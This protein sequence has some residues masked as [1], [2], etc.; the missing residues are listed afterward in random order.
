M[1][2]VKTKSFKDSLVGME[3]PCTI[4]EINT[5]K[6]GRSIEDIIENFGIKVNRNEGVDLI[7]YGVEVKSR[8]SYAGTNITIATMQRDYVINTPYKQSIA[9]KKLQQLRIVDYDYDAKKGVAVIVAD[10]VYDWSDPALQYSFER[11]YERGR[12]NLS[13]GLTPGGNWEL[14][15]GTK[16]SFIFQIYPKDWNTMKNRFESINTF[17]DIFSQ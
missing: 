3:I 8:C 13:L 2:T 6:I 10:K 5:G 9:Y 11:K 1:T 7:D 17:D 12:K 14:K 4:P 15:T 16:H